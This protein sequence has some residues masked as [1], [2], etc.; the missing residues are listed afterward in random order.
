[1]LDVMRKH[2]QSWGH[3]APIR[4]YNHRFYPALYRA[5]GKRD[6]APGGCTVDD[7]NITLSE[8][9]KS[10]DNIMSTTG[11][12]IRRGPLKRC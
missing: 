12:F 5:G 2:A 8:Y 10:Y 7:A 11:A 1:M 3:K 6:W 9:Q 4:R